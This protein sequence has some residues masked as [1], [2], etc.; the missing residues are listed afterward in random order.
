MLSKK[1]NPFYREKDGRNLRGDVH[2]LCL[3]L[4]NLSVYILHYLRQSADTLM[5]TLLYSTISLSVLTSTL[6]HD[7]MFWLEGRFYSIYVILKLLLD[8]I[9]LHCVSFNGLMLALHWQVL[10]SN[11]SDTSCVALVYINHHYFCGWGLYRTEVH[12]Q[13][14]NEWM[15]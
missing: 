7:D 4:K 2:I 1:K 9:L 14:K 13:T 12:I 8:R 10:R 3:C 15:S 11:F 5:L 6:Q